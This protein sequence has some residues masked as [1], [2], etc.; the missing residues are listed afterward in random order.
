VSLESSRADVAAGSSKAESAPSAGEQKDGQSS[1]STPHGTESGTLAKPESEGDEGESKHSTSR[2]PGAGEKRKAGRG[3]KSD[4][5]TRSSG[6]GPGAAQK[7]YELFRDAR[8]AVGGDQVFGTKITHVYGRLEGVRP[9]V[10]SP[11][12]LEAARKAFVK[13]E[14]WDVLRE[15]I[16]R[17]P[18]A[19]L[20]GQAG[21]GRHTIALRLLISSGVTK[22]FE[23]DPGVNLDLLPEALEKDA[24]YLLFEPAEPRHLRA[25]TLRNLDQALLAANATLIIVVGVNVLADN[26]A[27]HLVSLPQPP[28][29]RAIF[30]RHLEWRAGAAAAQRLLAEPEAEVT[31]NEMLAGDVTCGF[32]AELAYVIGDQQ[33]ASF[34]AARVRQ[35][36]ER[37]K[38]DAFDAW[39]EGLQDM[40][41]RTFAI[42]LAVLN[43]E[44]YERVAQ[45]ALALQRRFTADQTIMK[46]K[47]EGSSWR[48]S[49]VDPFRASHSQRLERLHARMVEDGGGAVTKPRPDGA[50]GVEYRDPTYSVNVLERVWFGYQLQGTLLAWLGDLAD[51]RDIRTVIFASYA[52][53]SL[54]RF[55][56]DYI[57]E[58][59]LRDWA[60]DAKGLRREAVSFTLR[61]AA[62]E[63]QSRPRIERFLNDLYDDPGEW[64]LHTAALVHGVSLGDSPDEAL[65]ALGRLAVY[66]S[67]EQ[68]TILAFWVGGAVAWLM[69]DGES[70]KVAKAL[71]AVWRWCGDP[72]RDFTGIATFLDLARHE[73]R[74]DQPDTT[75]TPVRWPT[76]L[77]LAHTR[78]DY[79]DA[80]VAL[81]CKSLGPSPFYSHTE[82]MLVTWA[83]LAEV[84]DD[85]R[86]AFVRLV[87][88][89]ATCDARAKAVLLR[90]AALWVR[91]DT[92]R[93]LPRV[94]GAVR[95]VL[96][97]SPLQ[98]LGG[99]KS[100]RSH[101]VA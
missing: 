94:A 33:T 95:R 4:G 99:V 61:T 11:F 51:G 62:E 21:L 9:R 92:L 72:R 79:R 60:R 91:D 38:R 19:I 26:L 37:R 12:L 35:S 83:R 47:E 78:A 2:Q 93:P 63:P 44:P 50:R 24:G 8:V 10:V 57:E 85:V 73:R 70:R 49:R 96:A 52:A 54:T 74:I 13:P 16:R 14:D 20:A 41:T 25:H 22:H 32:A 87:R 3:D 82:R 89:V 80:I 101:Y 97:D 15:R 64:G 5:A 46:G 1:G 65:D 86:D 71:Q 7:Q 31:V 67:Q 39:F 53:G 48:G 88:S 55:S 6:G 45:A 59:L 42:A 69:A 68:D 34:N 100:V 75:S 77:R 81:W 36:V 98:E 23:L 66:A 56:F 29:A 30:D 58:N 27:E 28:S 40:E 76:L 18:T 17:R 90:Q 43:G 84:D